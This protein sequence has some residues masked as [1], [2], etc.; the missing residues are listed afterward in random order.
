MTSDDF[1]VEVN[2]GREL[3]QAES[4]LDSSLNRNSRLM[5]PSGG[6]AS[7]EVSRPLETTLLSHSGFSFT[8]LFMSSY[9]RKQCCTNGISEFGE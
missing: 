8:F 2:A 7:S 3:N 1:Q 4:G 5:D 6:E 9:K